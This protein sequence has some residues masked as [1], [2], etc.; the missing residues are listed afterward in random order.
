MLLGGLGPSNH[1]QA[2]EKMSDKTGKKVQ[3]F[4]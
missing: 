3:I 2:L 1:L 4:Q